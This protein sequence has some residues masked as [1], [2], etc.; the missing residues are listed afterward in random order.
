M[1]IVRSEVDRVEADLI[2][3]RVACPACDGVLRPWGHARARCC[4][5]RNARRRCGPDGGAAVCRRPPGPY[6]FG[7]GVAG[8]TPMVSLTKRLTY[9][10]S[11]IDPVDWLTSVS[12]FDGFF[13][14][15]R[16][17]LNRV[18][19]TW[20]DL[21]HQ[22]RILDRLDEL[23]EPYSH[24]QATRVTF[25]G[26]I[27]G[28]YSDFDYEPGSPRP[29]VIAAVV[30]LPPDVDP[31]LDRVREGF[32]KPY[33]G[34]VVFISWGGDDSRRVAEG[35]ASVLHDRLPTTEVFYSRNSIDPGDDPLRRILE[36]G[37]LRA[38]VLVAALTKEAVQRP[39]V[40]WEI[41]SA[42]ARGQLVLPIF[43]DIEPSEAPG[44][45]AT[46]VQGVRLGDREG[47]RQSH[48]Q[49]LS[50]PGGTH[51]ASHRP[52]I[53]SPHNLSRF[54]RSRHCYMR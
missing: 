49:D 7:P 12:I 31:M 22:T 38:R 34:D 21:D 47:M 26:D 29:R 10:G 39:W 48:G 41:A 40:I 44:P 36:D 46:K 50:E 5:A 35:L 19:V 45:L 52:G 2:G 25:H 54:A 16:R 18:S 1:L 3:G 17:V 24:G 30:G 8:S 53:R 37:R 6:R 28:G 20:T 15:E 9:R 33:E 11:M 4:G 23:R 27:P 43:A 51:G 42:W 14:V 32:P 13:G